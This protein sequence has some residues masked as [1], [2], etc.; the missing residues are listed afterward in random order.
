M[1]R[2]GYII[3][4]YLHLIFKTGIYVGRTVWKLAV[5]WLKGLDSIKAF[6]YH[7]I[8]TI[9]VCGSDIIIDHSWVGWG[10]GVIGCSIRKLFQLPQL[11]QSE[12]NSH[13]L[14]WIR[15]KFINFS[16]YVCCQSSF[17]FCFFSVCYR[18]TYQNLSIFNAFIIIID[19]M[20][21]KT[22]KILRVRHLSS[23]SFLQQKP[24]SKMV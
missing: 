11:L 23:L 7:I 12:Y 14:I 15:W 9:H 13:W 3:V 16:K 21:G 22:L 1:K 5:R 4:D 24:I 20:I 19:L 18:L 2:S 8:A 6:G 17:T 10:R